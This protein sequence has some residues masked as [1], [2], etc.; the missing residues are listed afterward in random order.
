MLSCRPSSDSAGPSDRRAGEWRQSRQSD[1]EHRRWQLWFPVG[2]LEHFPV[3]PTLPPPTPGPRRNKYHG[4]GER[5]TPERGP[6]SFL[7]R[8]QVHPH[9]QGRPIRFRRGGWR[10]TTHNPAHGTIDVG[11][12]SWLLCER[13]F[14]KEIGEF[15]VAIK[16]RTRLLVGVAVREPLRD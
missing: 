7:L 13:L 14:L 12:A 4:V 11:S 6:F 2:P 8:D 5:P 16:H 9:G 3:P 15:Q 1:C 10:W